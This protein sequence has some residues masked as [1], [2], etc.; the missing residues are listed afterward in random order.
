L[1]AAYVVGERQLPWQSEMIALLRDRDPYVRLAARRSL[2]VLS[3]HALA[4]Q[5]QPGAAAPPPQADS[6]AGSTAGPQGASASSGLRGA[7]LSPVVDFGAPPAAVAAGQAGSEDDVRQWQEWWAKNAPEKRVLRAVSLAQRAQ[8]ELDA[9]AARLSAA[10]VFAEPPRQAQQL[11]RYRDAKGIVFTEALGNAL[12]QLDGDARRTAREYLAERLSRMTVETLRSRL[13]DPRPEVRRAAALA[14]AMRD[15]RAAVPELIPLL[16]DPDERVVPA[17]RAGLRS[18]TG[19]DFG[20]APG[21][22]PEERTRAAARWKAWWQS[23]SPSGLR[24][25]GERDE[26]ARPQ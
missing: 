5:G 26:A 9:E 3:Y 17:V 23:T 11:T 8:A 24:A 6:S 18:L 2:V 19:Q 16:E 25:E 13:D 14:W 22:T 20:P 4:A 10:A 15:D 1:A 12:G 21:A 7:R